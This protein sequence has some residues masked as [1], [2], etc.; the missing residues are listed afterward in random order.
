MTSGSVSQTGEMNSQ[1]GAETPER[2]FSSCFDITYFDFDSAQ[3]SAETP[4]ALDREVDNFLTNPSV[5]VVV[6]RHAD[7]R[8]GRECNLALECL[9]ASAVADHPIAGSIDGLGI[10]EVTYSKDKH[11]LKGLNEKGWLKNRSVEINGE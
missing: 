11:L 8:G 6:N 5:R 10:K 7:Q 3:L 9:R 1:V 2:N 4:K